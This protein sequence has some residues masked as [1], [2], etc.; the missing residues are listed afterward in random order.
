MKR[1]FPN[2]GWPRTI[3]FGP[4]STEEASSWLAEREAA[5]SV[6]EPATI[7]SLYALAE[8]H[9]SGPRPSV[10]FGD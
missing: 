3:S 8:N 6:D 4:L 2:T 9:S 5:A 7:A 10:G 1:A